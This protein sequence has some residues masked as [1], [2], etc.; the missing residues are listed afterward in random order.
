M[1]LELPNELKNPR[2]NESVS[3]SIFNF[4]KKKWVLLIIFLGLFLFWAVGLPGEVNFDPIYMVEILINTIII[5]LPQ[6]IF[7]LV[8]M[9][10]FIWKFKNDK[11]LGVGLAILTIFGIMAIFAPILAPYSYNKSLYIC[12]ASHT[13]YCRQQPPGP[14]IIM[15]T[16][17]FGYDVYSRIIYGAQIPL[18]MS[19][20]AAFICFFAGVPLGLVSGYY[21]GRIDSILKTVSDIIVS[22]PA[23]LLA[24][25][26]STFIQTIQIFIPFTNFSIVDTNS[27]SGDTLRIILVVS[28]SVGL[29]YIPSFFVIV[30]SIV[31]QIRESSFVESAKVLGASDF[32]IMFRYI[33]PNVIAAPMALIPFSM[34]DAILT[35]AALAFLGIGILPPTPDW[36]YDL[37][38]AIPNIQLAPWLITFPGIM[39]F[40][41]AFSFALVGDSLNEKYNPLIQKRN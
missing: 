16:T 22:F 3:T 13:Q 24:I 21:G 35:A 18:Q 4:L 11:L 19:F 9:A 14:G 2:M 27:P 39:L 36:G 31:L 40:L 38:A 6:I 12:G 7:V 23:L 17:L 25:I 20:I 10:I 15:G 8:I 1:S 41:L 29:L 28:F 37:T 30:R 33:L 5:L 26:L 34:T 32:T